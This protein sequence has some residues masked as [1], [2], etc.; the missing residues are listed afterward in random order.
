[1][2]LGVEKGFDV[3]VEE[4]LVTREAQFHIASQ[5]LIVG[6]ACRVGQALFG[7]AV[8]SKAAAFL[9]MCTPY[10]VWST[11]VVSSAK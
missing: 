5:G 7:Q 8:A 6:D 10:R 11:Q 9:Y 1:M 4:M 3:A 2:A